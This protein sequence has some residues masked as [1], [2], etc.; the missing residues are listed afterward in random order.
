MEVETVVDR[1]LWTVADCTAARS[2]GSHTQRHPPSPGGRSQ[3]PGAQPG[4]WQPT[5]VKAA[6]P[7]QQMVN[8]AKHRKGQQIRKGSTG[9][10]DPKRMKRI[11]RLEQAQTV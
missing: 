11:E 9:Q 1:A 10:S 7:D 8:I 4:P 6:K 3:R 2:C 5:Q